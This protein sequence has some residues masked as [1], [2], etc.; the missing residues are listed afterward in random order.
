MNSYRDIQVQHMETSVTTG[1]Y[2]LSYRGQYYEAS[3]SVAEL[4]ACLQEKD[5]E[6]EAIKKY[7][8][9]KKQ[10]FSVE[11]V[12]SLIAKYITPILTKGAVAGRKSFLY[13]KELFAASAIDQF[14]DAFR[15]LFNY[16]WMFFFTLLVL[17]GD[18]RF[19]LATEELLVFDGAANV[20]VLAGVL[21]FM[22]L[23]S[24]FHE[25]G[26]ASACKFYGIRHGGIG[27]G[28][29]L[30][31]P[32]LYTDVT[33]VWRLGRKQRCMVN[34]AGVYFQMYV[35]AALLVVYYWTGYDIVR[36]MVLIIN[37]GFLMTLNPFFKFDGYWIASDLLG[38]PNL[39]KRSREL[40]GYWY[41]KIRGKQ[42]IEKPYLLQINRWERYGLLFYSVV[43]NIFMGYYFFYVLPKFVVGFVQSFP[44]EMRQLLLYLSNDMAP[45][46][47]LLRNIAM[48]LLLLG[49]IGFMLF[50]LLKNVLKYG[51]KAG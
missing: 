18:I 3:A 17:A 37:L 30:T 11:E 26:H 25:L 45:S 27:F 4:L 34:L 40:L 51:G 19:F 36:Y 28:L 5:S 35:L 21:G 39:R 32:V 23:S 43:V 20:Y 22:L 47:A 44:D 42:G 48:Q 49:L 29:Y 24:L 8:E 50:R 1:R 14:S 6:T 16:K 15:C 7:I 33:E 2:L 9:K 31:F 10:V 38:V 41:G 46:F 13:E 12:E